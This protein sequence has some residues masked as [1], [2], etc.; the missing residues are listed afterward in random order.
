MTDAPRQAD[1]RVA[2][3]LGRLEEILQEQLRAY[4][5]LLDYLGRK[6]EAVRTA[7]MELMTAICEKEN[8]IAQRLA[9][10]EKGRLSLVGVLTEALAPAAQA[11][12]TMPRIAESIEEPARGRLLALAA[13]LRSAVQE[14]RRAS[15]VVRMAAEALARHMAGIRQT[16]QTVMS[17]AQVYGR[18]GQIAAGEQA[19]FCV[20]VKS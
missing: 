10:L 17:R 12:L 2:N 3:A 20:D 15:S 11:P 14:T 16:V 9:E 8:G 18:R 19:Q 7:D 5:Q 1:G 13:Q 4:G 6:R